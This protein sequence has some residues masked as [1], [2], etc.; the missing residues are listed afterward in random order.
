MK[1]TGPISDSGPTDNSRITAR[2]EIHNGW[3]SSAQGI[4]SQITPVEKNLA[5]EQSTTDLEESAQ[6]E[7]LD[8]ADDKDKRDVQDEE[9]SVNA[10][11][12]EDDGYG[13]PGSSVSDP[14]SDPDVS[15]GR[16]IGG[17]RLRQHAQHLTIT[18]NRIRSLERRLAALEKLPT[19]PS[20][21]EVNL[22]DEPKP[23]FKPQLNFVK[24]AQ[25]KATMKIKEGEVRHAIDVLVGEPI[26]FHQRH[27]KNA[28]T[29]VTESR[30]SQAE[31]DNFPLESIPERIRIN[32]PVLLDVLKNVIG[33]SFRMQTE[34]TVVLRPYKAFTFYETEL[35]EA[36]E[37][38]EKSLTEQ[39]KQA[40]YTPTQEKIH[41]S[42]GF[43]ENLDKAETE[44]DRPVEAASETEIERQ[45]S[46]QAIEELRGL[47]RFVE[48]LS[49]LVKII[50][51]K[52]T[53]LLKA[54][55]ATT[56]SEETPT[57]KR[58]KISVPFKDLWYIFQPGEYIICKGS[59][60]GYQ[61]VWRIVQ[62]TGGRAYLS[63]EGNRDRV[64]GP[65]LA[66]HSPLVLDC[67]YLDFDGKKFG[68]VYHRF[69][70][71]PF[72]NNRD[73]SS[74]EV[75]PIA[76]AADSET[77]LNE[78]SKQGEDF[79]NAIRACQKYCVGR[80][81][82]WTPKGERI[83]HHLHPEDVDGPVMVDFD[84]AIQFNPTWSPD[85][86]LPN[87]ADQDRRETREM[88]MH[89]DVT[90][91]DDGNCVDANCC[92]NENILDDYEWDRQRMDD[93]ISTEDI[94]RSFNDS[95][96]FVSPLPADYRLC[97]NRV[98]GF[99][100]RSRKWACLPV[101]GLKE[102]K[103]ETSNLQDLELPGHHKD[104]VTG[105]A[106]SH[107]RTKAK[108]KRAQRYEAQREFDLV[109]AKGKGLIILLHGAPGVGKTSTAECIA[110]ANATPLFPITCG[111]LGLN[112]VDVEQNLELNFQ[113]AESWGCVLLLDEADVFLAQRTQNDIKRNALVSIFLRALEY[114]S[115]ILFL[116]TNRVGTID[117]A[118]RSRIH[119]SLLYPILSE[120]QTMKIW[121]SQ[122]A[123]AQK[124][125]PT[126]IV[127]ADDVLLFAKNLHEQQMK[128]RKVGWNG[129][130]IR[131]AMQTA[132]ALAEYDSVMSSPNPETPQSPSLEI[133]WF[134][135]IASASWQFEAYLED[136]LQ[137][138]A[139][140]YAQQ[141][142][143]R[144]DRASTDHLVMPEVSTLPPSM[145]P[146]FGIKPMESSQSV[147][148]QTG[149]LFGVAGDSILQQ[150]SSAGHDA[151]PAQQWIPRTPNNPPASA[152]RAQYTPT[153]VSHYIP[154]QAPGN[155]FGSTGDVPLSVSQPFT[156]SNLYGTVNM[157]NTL[158]QD[159]LLFPGQRRAVTPTHQHYQYYGAM[160][161]SSGH[162]VTHP[163]RD[164]VV[165]SGSPAGN[166]TMSGP[167]LTQPVKQYPQP[168]MPESGNSAQ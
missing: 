122:L 90:C 167:T 142:S 80:T 34:P 4:P 109:R 115:G 42:E 110:E 25:F 65:H 46:V 71:Q 73:V 131:N 17:K 96:D 133:K 163:W 75:F 63:T 136:A 143:M 92:Q 31:D 21:P 70:I 113:L 33:G 127:K 6:S 76:Y 9:D 98:F 111:D 120:A 36:L 155:I 66:K 58:E 159:S 69:D 104:I 55:D 10:A 152:P 101:S 18:E 94:L 45:K 117:E 19:R 126:L 24:W 137:L 81:R 118:F 83:A 105:L 14:L 77:I 123:R 32:S 13:S 11:D 85:F 20:T 67:Y 37:A 91:S 144:A 125:D 12:D 89:E 116:T 154:P 130:Q 129:R 41:S 68:P 134:N 145:Q 28:R 121:K 60:E 38:M 15:Y 164:P 132:V 3:V 100:L 151:S 5:N 149:S 102:I 141:I 44:R 40:I 138:S 8:D 107:F 54:G 158:P 119:M 27:R 7:K 147:H 160:D 53:Q 128:K 168:S 97:P 165:S 22:E 51:Q 29:I 93:F 74:L 39:S 88:T 87:F 43:D 153:P 112:P 16:Q 108:E 72:E 2:P 23:I 48:A 114:Y 156:L 30:F 1:S 103:R 64:D 57:Q 139:R 106:E 59:K 86:T 150:P 35:R 124:R 79:V 99:I 157:P 56:D 95:S 148:P 26:L 161:P 62:C 162:P 84:R 50:K 47:V 140:E 135:I 78:L 166:M 61:R 49:P 52:P 146:L 82:T